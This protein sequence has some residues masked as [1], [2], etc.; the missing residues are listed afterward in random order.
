MSPTSRRACTRADPAVRPGDGGNEEARGRPRA[1]I[2]RTYQGEVWVGRGTRNLLRGIRQT[3]R[4]PGPASFRRLWAR[5]L[6]P[7]L[8]VHVC[9]SPEE[10]RLA[11]ASRRALLWMSVASV[12]PKAGRRA[13]HSGTGALLA[14]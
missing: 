10:V 5:N 14:L 13:A 11:A 3:R 2:A 9:C 1:I 8:V 6:L 4:H 7:V 12:P